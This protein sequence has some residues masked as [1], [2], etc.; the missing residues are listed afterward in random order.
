MPQTQ[1]H[2]DCAALCRP[3]AAFM[4][5]HSDFAKALCKN[6][7]EVCQVCGNERGK[8]QHDHCQACARAC[9]QCAQAC[10]SMAG[11]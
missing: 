1:A 4:A 10:L 11:A 2:I 8:H 5:R 6:C 3:A 9:Q 7:A